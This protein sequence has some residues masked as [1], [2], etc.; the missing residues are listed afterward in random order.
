PEPR[1]RIP[2][3]SILG[4]LAILVFAFWWRGHTFA[5]SVREALGISPWPVV[6]ARSEPLDCDEAAYAY[7]GHRMVGHGDV[8][9]RDLSENK[10]PGGYWLYALAVALGGYGEWAVRLLPIPLV[11][12]T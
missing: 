5:P 11:L 4:L 8:L 6:A 1:R 12:G 7:M 2:A 3:W 10:P 9:Y